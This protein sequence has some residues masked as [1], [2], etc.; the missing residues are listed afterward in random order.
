MSR[1]PGTTLDFV[2]FDPATIPLDR[3]GVVEASAGTGKT[4]SITLLYLRCVIERELD[5]DRILVV[6]FTRA[7]TAELRKR[8]REGLAKAHAALRDADLAGCDETLR[9]LLTPYLGEGRA[10]ATARLEA[11]LDTLDRA[12]ISTI[13]GFLGRILRQRAFE[14]CEAFE[15]EVGVDAAP[16]V[17]RIAADR[18]TADY[19]T[20][21][22]A[23]LERAS[24]RKPSRIEELL[25][26]TLPHPELPVVPAR[27]AIDE[28]GE[29]ERAYLGACAGYRELRASAGDEGALLAIAKRVR[30]RISTLK[31]LAVLD[32]IVEGRRAPSGT[33]PE[34]WEY[35]S[36]R[37]FRELKP[38]L[39]P[40]PFFDAVDRLVDG[41]TAFAGAAF[42]AESHAILDRARVDY[43]R[44][45]RGSGLLTFDA[46]K[47]MVHALLADPA[48]GPRIARVIAD[49]YAI[50]LVDESQDTDASQFEVFERIFAAHGRGL[51]FIGDPKQAIYGFRGADVHA[52]LEAR[53]N[54]SSAFTMTRNFRSHPEVIGSLDALYGSTPDAFGGAAIRYVPVTAGRALEDFAELEDPD[55]PEALAVLRAPPE[56]DE[57]ELTAS[58][59]VRLLEGG[60]WTRGGAEPRPVRPRDLA[61]LC[62]SNRE[63]DEVCLALRTRGVPA[64]AASN[65]TVFQSAEAR[66][67]GVF[68]R[69]ALDPTDARAV[70]AALL[71]SFF[72]LDPHALHEL[73]RDDSAWGA[74][75]DVLV[76]VRDDLHA[77][78]IGF[79]FARF[80]RASGLT[81]RLL[82][83]P[84]GFRCVTNLTHLVELLAR[85]AS[86]RK[87]GAE[88]MLSA[89]ERAR[90]GEVM[91]GAVSE[92]R[93]LRLE[94]AGDAV[95]VVTIHKSKGLEYPIVFLHGLA[96]GYAP[97][98]PKG[99]ELVRHPS[100][101]R[102]VSLDPADPV[103][104]QAYLDEAS[105]EAARLVYVALTRAKSAIRIL[106]VEGEPKADGTYSAGILSSRLARL[107]R[108]PLEAEAPALDGPEAY[109]FLER[110][111]AMLSERPRVSL[112][113]HQVAVDAARPAYRPR[114]APPVL[115]APA[116]RVRRFERIA[117]TSSFS[118]LVVGAEGLRPVDH[119]PSRTIASIVAEGS[120]PLEGVPA[121]REL[122][123]AIHAILEEVDFDADREALGVATDRVLVRYPSFTTHRE[124][125]IE[126]LVRSLATPLAEGGP[127]LADVPRGRT[128]RELEFQISVRNPAGFSAAEVAAL[129][130]AHEFPTKEAG[131]DR[132]VERLPFPTLTGYLRG[133]VDLVFEHGGR[134]SVVDHKS[135]RLGAA[136]DYDESRLLAP[137]ASH[138]Y[139]LQVALYTLALHRFLRQRLRGYDYDRH[140]G[141]AY[142]LFLRGM[143][144]SRGASSGV[145]RTRPGKALVEALDRLFEG[146]PR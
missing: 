102:V 29:L 100:L 119:D 99:P 40:P 35:L 80:D 15:A 146:D 65:R 109:A 136:G 93:A 58:E 82:A 50:A 74:R 104:K 68:L 128:L 6:T 36:A 34:K 110:R 66:E 95:Q 24:Y 94:H 30:P 142:Y 59:I 52:Y 55:R 64:V 67:L 43:E 53:G 72:D 38:E 47:S 39:V 19:A 130:A 25:A 21:E 129:F 12:S 135:N 63:V 123:V 91:D 134:F 23:V 115:L 89:F 20:L 85:T 114:V 9:A 132:L 79:A 13:D 7:A 57:A 117:R 32:A 45:T 97:R 17:A 18:Y 122:G 131:Y 87:L 88:A 44:A 42:A 127:R 14:T 10:S 76:R 16:I 78:G 81:T 51:V 106:A 86:E 69:A 61:V 37:S 108:G 98:K 31:A 90:A 125:L 126:A 8:I 71:S 113:V 103:L 107:F 27:V 140:V 141:D 145:Y 3:A 46:L 120:D 77:R 139:L 41:A 62:V 28:V 49:E 22:P 133:F 105:D 137:M 144:P 83:R 111:F 143:E 4:Y 73:S 121:G 118:G 101:G 92:E 5:P 48:R 60:R 11:A 2:A 33:P 75:V 1:P 138:H 26:K 70:R 116:P 96:S 124:A 56:T 112:A 54:A 84:D